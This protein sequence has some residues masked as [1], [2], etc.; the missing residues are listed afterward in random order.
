MLLLLLRLLAQNAH[1]V[2]QP[3]GKGEQEEEEEQERA[4]LVD[5]GQR[6]A[7]T[8]RVY[9][10]VAQRQNEKLEG[11][12]DEQALALNATGGVARGIRRR[13]RP[14]EQ[15][16]Q[17][18]EQNGREERHAEHE[19]GEHVSKVLGDELLESA[20]QRR[21]GLTTVFAPCNLLVVSTVVLGCRS[22]VL[23]DQVV[24]EIAEISGHGRGVALRGLPVVLGQNLNLEFGLVLVSY[25]FF[26]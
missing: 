19:H 7:R 20:A 12:A 4:Q 23:G 11:D 6:V 8:S 25:L 22:A 24:A 21:R 18:Y 1:A 10:P 9:R 15:L 5:L 26:P 3:E 13:R 16:G 17:S 2:E 14:A